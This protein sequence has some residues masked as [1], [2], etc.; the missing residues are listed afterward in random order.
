LTVGFGLARFD[1]NFTQMQSMMQASGKEAPVP[2]S[3]IVTAMIAVSLTL[4]PLFNVLFAL[5]EEI[6]WRGFLLPRLVQSGVDQWTALLA[7]GAIWGLWH[8][9]LIVRGQNYPDHPY[10]GV[11]LMTLFCSLLGVIFGW[12]R[13]ASKSVW[14]PTLAHGTLNA[15]AGVPLLV[16]TPFD[17]ALG[18]ML[19][20]LVG[21]LPQVAFIGWL[22]WS[23]R[24][25]VRPAEPTLIGRP[26]V[27]PDTD[28]VTS[29][30]RSLI[31]K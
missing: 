2:L 25:P 3:I 9:P 7:S 21:W 20:S 11:V 17:M 6:G 31:S 12:L 28:T 5:G 26:C 16:L 18:G 22:A 1:A 23:G 10:L 13:L 4:A 19:T 14:P 15:V 29:S 27:C 8:A 24:L 30:A